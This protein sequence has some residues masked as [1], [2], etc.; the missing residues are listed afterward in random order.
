MY[1]IWQAG[2]REGGK[3]FTPGPGGGEGEG[4]LVACLACGV[5]SAF[6][7]Q[8]S[9]TVGVVWAEAKGAALRRS[10]G[11]AL[12]TARTEGQGAATVEALSYP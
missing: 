6:G 5:E 9:R 3:A 8:G 11:N 4:D 2:G 10:K 1:G 7:V 12:Q